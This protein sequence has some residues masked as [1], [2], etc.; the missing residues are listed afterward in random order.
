MDGVIDTGQVQ[1]LYH[2]GGDSGGHDAA[3]GDDERPPLADHLDAGG[4]AR[5]LTGAEEGGGTGRDAELA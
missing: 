5:E 3:V 1:Q 2:G 4:E